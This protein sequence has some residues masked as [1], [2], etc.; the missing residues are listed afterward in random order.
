MLFELAKEKEKIPAYDILWRGDT[1]PAYQKMLKLNI[2]VQ[3]KEAFYKKI[4]NHNL[5]KSFFILDAHR[6]D[7]ISEIKALQDKDIKKIREIK[8]HHARAVLYTY[9]SPYVVISFNE[10]NLSKSYKG[11]HLGICSSGSVTTPAYLLKKGNYEL[12]VN[13]KGINAFDAYAKLKIQIFKPEKNKNSL[14]AEKMID[15]KQNFI[16]FVV[17]F[18]VKEDDNILFVVS[19]INDKS[20]R[21]T[22]EDR[23]AYL[24]S[25]ILKKL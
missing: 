2:D 9:T 14:I 22:K 6:G 15:T 4:N 12:I 5:E 7:H 25:I 10:C 24:K 16:D 17:P 23:N 21:K 13:A 18:K 8:K 20:D 11:N 3:S 19:F 1:L